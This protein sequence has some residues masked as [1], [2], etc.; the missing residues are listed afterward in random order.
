MKV[1]AIIAC[2]GSGLRAGFGFNKLLKDL[3]GVT[4]IEKCLSAFIESGVIDEFIITCRKEDESAFKEIALRLGVSPKFVEGGSTRSLSVKAGLNAVTGEVVVI[5]DGARP[6]VSPEIIRSSVSSAEE[7]GSGVAAIPAVDTICDCE[8]SPDGVFGRNSS[9]QGKYLVQTP[10][11]FK[12]EL[13]KKAY[14]STDDYSRFTDESGLFAEFIGKFRVIDG[15]YDNVKLTYKKDFAPSLR[16]GTGFDLHRLVEGR[17]L[18]LG[19]VEIPHDK[20]LLGHSDA[21]VLTHAIMDALLS[22]AALGDIGK[23]FPDTDMRYK[24]ISSM[25]LLDEVLDLLKKSGY[26]PVNVTAVIM[27]EKPKLAKYVLR[28]REN[29]AAALA[30][31]LGDVGLTCT[32]LEGIGTVGREE[33]IAVQAHCL[34]EKLWEK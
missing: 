1:S 24:G 4:P 34:T 12:T 31:P 5:H 18:I 27:A 28:I 22:S 19:G 10:Q 25:K 17:K 14:S 16:C 7:F 26:K 30:L 20:G 13:I 9:R 33:G 21:D 23:H 32:T 3:G 6:F 11:T 8:V 29:L 2:A 15:S